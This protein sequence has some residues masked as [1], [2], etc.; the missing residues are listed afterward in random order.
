MTAEEVHSTGRGPDLL[1][2]Y[3]STLPRAL[4]FFKRWRNVALES[5]VRPSLCMTGQWSQAAIQVL[6]LIP[7]PAL[8]GSS[9]MGRDSDVDNGAEWA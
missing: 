8:T 9:T 6:L 5:S 1:L 4:G 3:G 7:E 2:C